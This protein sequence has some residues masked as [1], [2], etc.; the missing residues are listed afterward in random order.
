MEECR[1]YLRDTLCESFWIH[2][3]RDD[4]VDNCK[5]N[6]TDVTYPRNPF[7]WPDPMLMLWPAP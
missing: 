3:M 7:R 4:Q 6:F 5:T 1:A 2:Q